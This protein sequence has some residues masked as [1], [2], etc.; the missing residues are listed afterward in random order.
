[1]TYLALLERADPDLAKIVLEYRWVA[2]DADISGVAKKILKVIA[3][4][5]PEFR[6]GK[7]LK[8]NEHVEV[9]KF[10]IA[11][12]DARSSKTVEQVR[13]FMYNDRYQMA[14]AAGG[15]DQEGPYIQVN[16]AY[17]SRSELLRIIFH[18]LTH[19]LDPDLD[20]NY[21]TRMDMDYDEEARDSAMHI[22]WQKDDGS[23]R[24]EEEMHDLSAL[25]KLF[26][27]WQRLWQIPGKWTDE[28]GNEWDVKWRENLGEPGAHIAYQDAIMCDITHKG[29]L[30]KL[31]IYNEPSR[32]HQ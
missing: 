16:A 2:L 26:S 6:S 15:R 21:Y 13:V 14:N 7:R 11:T 8:W 30:Y 25:H 28:K 5:L 27:V 31:Y 18:E 17:A 24:T 23:W 4:K 19:A 22:S 12:R 9:A 10:P 3:K 20:P 32:R 29:R 1:M